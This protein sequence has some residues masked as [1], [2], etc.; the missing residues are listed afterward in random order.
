MGPMS[1]EDYQ[2]DSDLRTM[3]EAE[4]IRGDPKRLSRAKQAL[5]KKSEAVNRSRMLLRGGSAPWSMPDR[6]GKE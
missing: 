1:M 4:A 6:K 2:A 5:D 3:E